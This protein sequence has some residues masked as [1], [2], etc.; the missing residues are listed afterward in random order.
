[1][2]AD[3]YAIA[4]LA[5]SRA[6][7]HSLIPSLLCLSPF[8]SPLYYLISFF[9]KISPFFLSLFRYSQSRPLNN[10]A[11]SGSTR[12]ILYGP[13]TV[14]IIYYFN[15]LPGVLFGSIYI[16]IFVRINTCLFSRLCIQGVS[17]SGG[18]YSSAMRGGDLPRLESSR[19]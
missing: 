17:T 1:M 19:S 6:H 7:T 5:P 18:A 9:P 4:S 3:D 11:S 10:R 14:R 2:A 13:R 8:L 12:Y 15:D 16:Y